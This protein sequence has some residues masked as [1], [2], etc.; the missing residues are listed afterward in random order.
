METQER[1][2]MTW[3]E[4]IVAARE[5][6]S[7]SW[8]DR[9]DAIHWTTCAVGEQHDLHPTVVVGIDHVFHGGPADGTLGVLG[10]LCCFQGAVNRDD[11]DAAELYLD[12]I[13]DRVLELKREAT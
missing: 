9:Q 7:F 4:R 6:G 2:P 5:R 12:Q 8:A 1:N 3:R 11:F 10:S 13:E